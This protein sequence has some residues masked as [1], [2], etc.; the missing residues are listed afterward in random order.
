MGILVEKM[1]ISADLD[2]HVAGG[3]MVYPPG[4]WAAK[5]FPAGRKKVFQLCLPL[6]F[7]F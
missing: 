4:R 5:A 6:V 1:Q 2:S 7:T 3:A